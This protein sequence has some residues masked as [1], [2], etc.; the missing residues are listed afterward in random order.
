[1]FSVHTVVSYTV[2]GV[3][4]RPGW[5]STIFGPYFVL[6]ALFSGTAAIITI[7]FLVRL[8]YPDFKKIIT[9]RHFRNLAVIL[10]VL[11]LGYGYFTLSEYIGTLYSTP[12]PEYELL[13]QLIVGEYAPLFLF[14]IFG[15]II[16]P[17]VIIFLTRAKSIPWIV[18]ASILINLGMWVKRYVIIV[19]SM[20]RPWISGPWA[21]Y[22]PT[23]VELL[24]TI[25]A[26][27]ALTFG[28]VIS[29]K[30]FPIS[31]LWEILEDEERKMKLKE[32]G[33]ESPASF[34][35]KTF[36]LSES[37]LNFEKEIEKELLSL[38]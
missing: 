8:I 31:P 2:G 12:T 26:F 27:A 17:G 33:V 6:G 14:A 36:P 23:N 25:G 37:A 13:E 1:M 38:E 24:I 7:M 34:A 20:A 30:I 5:R 9:E 29:A 16:L 11:S 21:T 4:L 32:A 10:L 18:F 35:D 19:P 22:T 3:M 15:G 28:I